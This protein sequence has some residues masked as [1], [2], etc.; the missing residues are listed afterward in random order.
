MTINRPRLLPILLAV[1]AGCFALW[2]NSAQAREN[3]PDSP[4]PEGIVAEVAG[5]RLSY[6]AF[7]RV[8]VSHV[9]RD[10]MEHKGGPRAV[11]DQL[12]EERLVAARC[13][14]R[15][16][17][18]RP[19]DVMAKERDLE[20][21]IRSESGGM[22]SLDDVL[23]DQGTTRRHFREDL[24]HQLRRQRLANH[25]LK[26]TLDG[27]DDQQRVNQT[28]LVIA[29]LMQS[30]RAEYALPVLGALT[31]TPM[32]KGIVAKIDGIPVDRLSYGRAL[33]R[34]L[35]SDEVRGYLDRECKIGLMTGSG[36][37]IK[38]DTTLQTE[39]AH[40]EGIWPVERALRRQAEWMDVSF[41]DRFKVDF[42]VPRKD[43]GR[44]RFLRGLFGIVRHMR[45]TVTDAELQAAYSAAKSGKYGDHL[46][47]TDVKIT[48]VQAGNPFGQRG[49]SHRDA[50]RAA[51]KVYTDASSGVP[52]GRIVADIRAK[53]DPTFLA[54]K[55]RIYPS[56]GDKARWKRVT[57]LRDGEVTPPVDGLSEVHVY[58]RERKIKGRSFA[59]VRELVRDLKAREK[60]RTWLEKRVKDPK[61]VKLRWPLKH[62]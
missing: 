2:P 48:F 58:R 49:L 8:L 32:E 11:L 54:T 41:D 34:R 13:T 15:S 53:R 26:G 43:A 35:D 33:A 5:R 22:K 9:R 7:C 39:L 24:A 50:L 14:A 62:P 23:R 20:R 56:D 29:K 31:P 57:E 61:F 21:S 52:F 17:H 27:L 38:D 47:V 16:L 42:K 45:G 28:R 6:D 59:E 12:L 10:L 3:N 51:R 60:A 25:R 18:V 1:A 44:S 37:A 40:M 55:L 46:L 4:L 30:A 36:F 19:Q